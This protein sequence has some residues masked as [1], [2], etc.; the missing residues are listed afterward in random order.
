[1]LF[2]YYFNQVISILW[3]NNRLMLKNKGTNLQTLF[4]ILKNK[5]MGPAKLLISG[6]VDLK[7]NDNTNTSAIVEI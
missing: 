4:R 7:K 2:L 1:M 5:I 3:F 6:E